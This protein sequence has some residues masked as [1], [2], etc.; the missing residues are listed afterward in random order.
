MPD[1]RRHSGSRLAV[2]R[3]VVAADLGDLVVLDSRVPADA[4]I[5]LDLVLESI[6]DGVVVTGSVDAAFEA[7]CRRCLGEVRGELHQDLR[8]IFE[9]HPPEGETYPIG[10]DEVDLEPMVREAV[11]LG[12]PAAPLCSDDCR[13]PV[14]EAFEEGD[15]DPQPDP[16]WAAL[17]GLDFDQ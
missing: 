15:P 9:T 11:L 7:V 2:E 16:R 17:E 1:I 5:R 4:T 8:E 3:E 6:P 14:P 13:G 12:L 10:Q